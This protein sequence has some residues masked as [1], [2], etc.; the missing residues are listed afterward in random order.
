VIINGADGRM[1]CIT[2]EDWA[3]EQANLHQARQWFASSD[4]AAYEGTKHHTVPAFCLRQFA[5]D[6]KRLSVW[7]WSTGRITP[8]A[9]NDLAIKDFYT[10]QNTDGHF[11]GRTEEMLGRVEDEAAPVVDLLLSPFRGRNL[12]QKQQV[13]VCQ[14]IAFQMV[15]GPRKR[16]EIE[17]LADYG[18]KIMSDGS[19]SPAELRDTIIVPHPNEH[20]RMMGP[21]SEAIFLSILRRPVQV[22][23]LDAP[24]LVICDEPVLVDGADHV[25]HLPQCFLSLAERRKL[26]PEQDIIH[27]WPT[28]PSGVD[29][30][31]AI[32]MPVT[33]QAIIVLGPI[34]QPVQPILRYDGDEARELAD[35]VN[36]AL[37][38]QAHE[39]VAANPQHPTFA[40]WTFPPPS[41]L[42]GACDGG[43]IMSQQLQTAPVL[44]WQR[45]RK[46][47]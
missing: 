6:R 26:N 14:F 38:R 10:T 30:A 1:N 32:A 8:S 2:P 29:Q 46:D 35:E 39:W 5:R 23:W 44:K 17:L 18:S 21:V 40:K 24:L 41:P 37:V 42:L 25:R 13:A 20:I 36:S 22:I 16:K 3:A 4:L 27:V 31:D 47:W 45:I 33:P 7:R 28:K 19:M 11:D 15:R 12:S 9:V 34:G 43:S